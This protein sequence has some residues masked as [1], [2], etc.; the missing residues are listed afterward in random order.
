MA[1]ILLI[2][3][4]LK[5]NW[6][7]SPSYK[8]NMATRSSTLI[9]LTQLQLRPTEQLMLTFD[10]QRLT[11]K[12]TPLCSCTKSL[13]QRPETTMERSIINQKIHLVWNTLPSSSTDNQ[14][15]VNH[16]GLIH[17]EEYTMRQVSALS[18][19]LL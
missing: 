18:P 5:R 15:N 3:R 12:V 14:R 9:S 13:H 16:L 19:M 11:S 2:R 7:L 10:H 4:L 8:R 17:L 6:T 1:R